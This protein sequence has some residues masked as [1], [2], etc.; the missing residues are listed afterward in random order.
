MSD[1]RSAG[2]RRRRD[3]LLIDLDARIVAET[4]CGPNHGT[5]ARSREVIIRHGWPDASG[6]NRLRDFELFAS[7]VFCAVDIKRML[8]RLDSCCSNDPL[9]DLQ[10]FLHACRK[11]LRRTRR[12]F[13]SRFLEARDH[14][15]RSHRLA[16]F[17]VQASND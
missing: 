3:R 11:F 12:D 4:C 6:G 9:D 16:H 15:R 8:F 1:W 2:S 14:V 10:I 5:T 7:F 13:E 17:L